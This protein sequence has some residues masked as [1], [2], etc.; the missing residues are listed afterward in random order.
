LGGTCWILIQPF[1][2]VLDLDPA[3]ARGALEIRVGKTQRDAKVARHGPL[4]ERAVAFDRVQ[5]AERNRFVLLERAGLRRCGV[6]RR[7]PHIVH[8]A[9]DIPFTG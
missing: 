7:H 2:A 4:G 8:S 9:N 6:T 5:D 3:F 1:R